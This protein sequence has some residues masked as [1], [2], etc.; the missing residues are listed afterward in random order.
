MKIPFMALDEYLFNYK[1]TGTL[2]PLANK[3]E[4]C[5]DEK[6]VLLHFFTN[7]D[8]NVYCAKDTLSSQLWAFLVGQYS[9]SSLSMRDRFLQLF[10]DAEKAHSK[11][12][13]KK[14]DFVSLYELADAIEKR[15]FESIDYFNQKASSFLKR[16]GVKYGHNS[17]KDADRIRFAIEGV[18]QVCTKAI[19]SPFPTLG[20]FQEKSTRYMNFGKESVIF[21]PVLAKSEFGDEIY[22]MNC[23]LMDIYQKYSSIV[24]EVLLSRGI[25]KREE[26]KD[27]KAFE[28]T[29]NAKTFDIIRY[30]LPS[31]VR[32]CLG[33]GFSARTTESHLSELL[34]H[35]IAEVKMVATTMW[36][37]AMKMSPALLSHVGENEYF[38][39]KQKKSSELTNKIFNEYNFGEIIKGIENGERVK[40][41]SADDIDE[42]VTASILF[43]YG[44]AKG[45]SFSECLNKAK[46]MCNEEK[47]K[48]IASELDGRGEFDRMPRTIR[49]GR[50][51]CEFFHD[52]GG[53][54]D[55][56]RHRAS[57]QQWQGATAIH[58]FD[59]P[60]YADFD[61]LKDF[62]GEYNEAMTEVTK[63]SRKVIG[64]HP[65]EAEYVSALGHLVR[66]T[67]EMHPGHLAYVIELRTTPQGHQSYRRIFQ[68]V[69]KLMLEKA[70]LFTKHI[71]VNQDSE[72]SRRKQEE[73]AA[74]KKKVYC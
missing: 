51:M 13:I 33:A 7:I 4:Y 72:A 9:R 42:V 37:E 73:K 49:H 17:L 45:V 71:K 62:K 30:A 12:K 39:S 66:Q 28:D 20:D 23:K 3:R 15:D 22:G 55:I 29:L 70:P 65:Y 67:F 14:G 50:I 35:P 68:E 24:K 69:Y 31:G 27:G 48:I 57:E 21:S 47:D 18:S 8:K 56:Q 38:V 59:Y 61:E 52:F 44:R 5:E 64:K 10:D 74:E 16:W 43:E 63:L 34:S 2:A 40:L 46:S 32:T 11:G 6:T 1:K 26:F 36:E 60:E 19:E 25:V 41:I 53:Y 58:G 54:R